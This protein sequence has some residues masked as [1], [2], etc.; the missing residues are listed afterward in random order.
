MVIKSTHLFSKLTMC[1]EGAPVERSKKMKKHYLRFGIIYCVLALVIF[2]AAVSFY[3][4][5]KTDEINK[6]WAGHSVINSSNFFHDSKT[7]SCTEPEILMQ[8]MVH[9][10]Q[11]TS[12]SSE[13]EGFYSSLIDTRDGFN[14]MF[15]T[16][17][18]IMARYYGEFEYEVIENSEE[19]Y[20]S[21]STQLVPGDLR[22]MI[23]DE[24]LSFTEDEKSEIR[25]PR[26]ITITG[27]MC[28]DK[29][30]YGGTL[31]IPS[32]GTVKTIDIGRPPMVNEAESVPYEDWIV[33]LD[34][35]EYYPIGENSGDRR[36]NM[37]AHKLNDKFVEEFKNGE[38]SAELEI[39]KGVFTTTASMICV[40]NGGN[41]LVTFYSVLKPFKIVLR[42][43]LKTYILFL[44][45]FILVEAVIV[46][47]V[48]KLY[49][50]Q[51]SFEIR[52]RKLTQ[53]I[54]HDLKEPLAATRA[55]VENWE[56]LDEDTRQEYSGKIIS[57]V[58]HM[59]S[60]V[61]RLL[62][63]SKTNGSNIKLNREDV[64]LRLLTVNVKNRNLEAIRKKN[65]DVTII[66]DETVDSYPV[67]ADLEM[68]YI[69]ISNF[70]SNAIKYCDHTVIVKLERTGRTIRFS[71]T[72][73]GTRIP[74]TDFDKIW[75]PGYGIDAKNPD[76]G[77]SSGV[78]LSVVKNILDAHQAKCVCY[79]GAKGTTFQFIMNAYDK[80][81]SET[82]EE[83]I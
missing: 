54:A 31:S 22:Y 62:E 21:R 66:S 79:N 77:E 73:D 64:D 6:V 46:F 17:D 74:N 65:A 70:M 72:N 75:D 59:S 16:A 35:L 55:H 29:F 26:D 82:G 61:T 49:L 51:K 1:T 81:S 47:A 12:Y 60:M 43:D 69:V 9:S 24:P 4:K 19:S 52:S 20:E 34:E 8:S 80:G 33:R 13:D 11:F 50:N 76:S 48:R 42:H 45:A 71:I 5:K 30:I 68:M 3:T 23:F 44:I 38:A 7:D 32:D 37:T 39:K 67:H 53:G 63:L 25:F 15:E 83:E 57:E 2:M 27:A 56:K 41:Y 78:G 36:L 58:D 10:W 18:V 28:D 14:V 40:Y